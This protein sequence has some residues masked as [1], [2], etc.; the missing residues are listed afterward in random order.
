MTTLLPTNER[1]FTEEMKW[2][3]EGADKQNSLATGR[4]KRFSVNLPKT[5]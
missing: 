3:D 5:K 4:A 2:R 1:Q